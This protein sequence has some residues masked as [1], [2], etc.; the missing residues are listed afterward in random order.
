[1]AKRT[2][3]YEDTIGPFGVKLKGDTAGEVTLIIY[4]KGPTSR[5]SNL[6]IRLESSG[7]VGGLGNMLLSMAE[8]LESELN[9]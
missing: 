1:M 2:V 7:E 4:D 6:H 5:P 8:D 9:R 3:E